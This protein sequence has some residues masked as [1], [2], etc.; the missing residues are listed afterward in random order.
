[1]N[2]PLRVAMIIQGYHPRVGG[3]E[4]QL[5]AVAPRLQARGLDVHVLTRRYPGL[6]AE[7]MVN[8]VPVHRLLI[9][10]PKRVG[11]LVFLAAALLKLRQL[12]PQVIHAHE[13]LSPTTTALAARR[14]WKT[15]VVAKVL[16]G[17]AVGDLAKLRRNSLSASRL[18]PL[19]TQVDRFIVVSR[20]IDCELE[21]AGI[22]PQRRAFIPNGVDCQRFAPAT[23]EQKAAA[24]AQL[25]LPANQPV[26]VFTGRI[27]PEKNL[28]LL[29]KLWPQIRL[30]APQASLILVGD[31]EQAAELRAASPQGVLWSG[32]VSDPRPYL[33]AADIFVLPSLTEGLS[34]ALLEGMA[35]GLASVS[36]HVGGSEDVIL[37][38]VNGCLVP[39]NDAAAL[40]D[41]LVHL[42]THP[43]TCARMG[44]A[45][46][47]RITQEY[48]LETTVA[49]LHS[50][51][52]EVTSQ[53]SQPS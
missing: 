29:L 20:E 3:A 45:S 43:E 4:R 15:P 25:G 41:A 9:P 42:V 14:L 5:A 47:E 36:S 24:R 13:L 28:A 50:L 49:R 16:R 22:P 48:D 21:A 46:R 53:R 18:R 7:E 19:Q 44:T 2:S 34:N 33:H 12:R 32:K 27:D 10:G 6:A 30:A 37:P 17:G 1:M 23:P 40:Q 52:L 8:G 11:T 39:P 51:Y 38:G 31:G 35:C 26:L